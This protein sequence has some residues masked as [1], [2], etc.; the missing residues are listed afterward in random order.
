MTIT[1]FLSSAPRAALCL[2]AASA[3]LALAQNRPASISPT[4]RSDDVVHLSEFQVT[5]SADDGYRATNALSGTRFNTSLLELPKAV[6]VI[7]SEFISDIGAVDLGEAVA[8]ATAISQA[9]ASANDD[10]TGS[11]F[12]VR[13][14]NT[15]TT[16][17]NGFR[18]FG[19]IDPINIDRIEI[20]K[21]P[22]SVFSGPIEPGGTIN[23]IT[24]RPST[25]AAGSLAFRYASYDSRRVEASAT[26]PLNA[27]RTIA[28]RLATAVSHTGYKYDYSGLDKGVIGGAV[29]WKRS[30][31][32]NVLFEGQFVNNQSKPVATARVI[33]SARTAYEPNIPANFNRNG[34]LAYSDV[35]QYS[36]T[37]EANHRFNDMWS[38]RA[39]LYYRYQSLSRFRDTGSA[40]M[41]TNAAVPGGRLLNRQGEYEPNADSY[42]LTP[43]V[44]VLGSFDYGAVQQRLI[45]GYE[46]F[47]E[48]TRNDV[49]RRSFTGAAALNLNA[50]TFDLGDPGTYAPSDLRRTWAEQSAYSANTLFRLFE[51]RMMALG[52]VRYSTTDDERKNLRT[53]GGVRVKKQLNVAVPNY[54]VSFKLR[55]DVALF[56]SYSESYLPPSLQ[57]ALTDAAGNPFPESTGDGTDVGLKFDLFGGRMTGNVSAFEI[58]RENTLIPDPINPGFRIAQ[59]RTTVRGVDT[60]FT[61]RPVDAWQIVA[62]Y[63]Y[64]DGRLVNGTDPN[65]RIGNVPMHKASLWN[66][67]KFATG[68]LKG[69][70]VGL[71]V[72]F[73][74]ERRGN[75]ALRD[76]P[77]LSSPGYTVYHANVSYQ[78]LIAQRP[79]AFTLQGNN[80]GNKEYFASAAGKGDPFTFAATVR[81]SFR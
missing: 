4:D 33:N 30:D 43:S 75:S 29:S 50:P 62:G 72:I 68:A 9:N 77:A 6:D 60:G 38:T 56:A 8:Y 7:T 63:S 13:G 58:N 79:W 69:F 15:F 22:S 37:L 10:I 20:I 44:N 70:G 25:K 3:P 26:G 11:N 54:G 40:V 61:L 12:N 23:T 34:P 31:A 42:V 53:P 18:H 76:L 36:G 47:Y 21:G 51:G 17:R 73:V 5:A 32:T 49:F 55:R 81:V 64:T 16:Y 39:G 66:K 67:Y 27:S 28:Y 57:G 52:G 65:G 71:G 59:G 46:Y 45:L 41:T 2:L 78:R 14:F 35:I 48:L 24:K 80:L 19:I 1:R 74:D